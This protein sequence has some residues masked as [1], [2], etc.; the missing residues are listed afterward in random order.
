LAFKPTLVPFTGTPPATNALLGGQVDYFCDPILAQMPHIRAGSLKGLAIASAA[1]HALLPEL[2]TAAEQGVPQ[3]NA[4]P[5]FALFAPKGTPAP[6]V[7]TLAAALDQ[8]LDD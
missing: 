3:F 2:P 8:A 5:F 1:R 6:V 7:E 4:S